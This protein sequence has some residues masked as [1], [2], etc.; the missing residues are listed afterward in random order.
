MQRYG[1]AA[2]SCRATSLAGMMDK[3]REELNFLAMAFWCG[4]GNPVELSRWTDAAVTATDT[5][6]PLIL[7]L[8]PQP[9][10]ELAADLL[11]KM[12]AD[13][14]GL[15]PISVEAEPIAAEVLRR[16][17]NAFATRDI[18]IQALCKLVDRLD[19]AFNL[20]LAGV[21]RPEPVAADGQWWL[22]DLYNCCDWCDDGWTHES[23]A[24]LHEEAARVSRMLGNK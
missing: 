11:L 1:G 15:Q 18:T 2:S 12:A 17:L 20:D 6:H 22:G 14:N 5:F 24:H 23:S 4:V 8:Y 3:L 16:S 7:E 21:P 19:A 9:T 10:P 13:L